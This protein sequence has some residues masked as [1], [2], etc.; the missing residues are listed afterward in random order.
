MNLIMLLL[1]LTEINVTILFFWLFL[2]RLTC[3]NTTLGIS[4]S[5]GGIFDCSNCGASRENV[6]GSRYLTRNGFHSRTGFAC[7]QTAELYGDASCVDAPPIYMG[8]IAALTT[9]ISACGMSGVSMDK[10]SRA[11]Q[12]TR[13]GNC[14]ATKNFAP[15]GIKFLT[16]QDR[17]PIS[18]A[19]ST[20]HL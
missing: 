20:L 17:T 19:V 18:P 16:P 15:P 4:N 5:E 13:Q 10:P 6:A 9:A 11:G 12:S 7:G 3:N 8:W 2:H 14:G 1:V